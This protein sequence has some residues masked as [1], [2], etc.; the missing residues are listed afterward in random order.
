MSWT[1]VSSL[2]NI[3]LSNPS[4]LLMKSLYL[5]SI[6]FIF[7][8]VLQSISTSYLFVTF[9]ISSRNFFC[10]EK[11]NLYFSFNPRQATFPLL[12]GS[13]LKIAILNLLDLG[14]LNARILPQKKKS[15]Q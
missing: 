15:N 13:I 14:L 9:I 12:R 7:L 10:I 2:R 6:C 11:L 3:I 1:L 4:R 8:F 5:S